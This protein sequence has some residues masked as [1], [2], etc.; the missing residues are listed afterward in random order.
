M[1]DKVI[2]E[3]NGYVMSVEALYC[4]GGYITYEI[5][6]SC[7]GFSGK[8]NFCIAENALTKYIKK[9]NYMLEALKGEVEIRDSESDAY[10]TAYFEDSMN[11]YM[12]GQIGGSYENNTLKFKMKTDQTL[13]Q[14]LKDK[15]LDY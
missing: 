4:V 3:D 10:L 2:Y 12:K 5:E 1:E 14:G 6:I 7:C 13:L 9:I 11:F 15:L 8:C